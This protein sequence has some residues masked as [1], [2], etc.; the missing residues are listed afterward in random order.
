MHLKSGQIKDAIACF[1]EEFQFND[2]AIGLE[3]QDKQRLAEFFQKIRDL[4]PAS[5]ETDRILPSADHV[6]IEWTLRA[7]LAES[8]YSGLSRRVPISVH[9]ATIARVEYG[10]VKNW[11]DYYDGLASRRTSA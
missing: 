10:H 6:I 4:Y 8:F 1:A 2:W 11:S 9:G 7:L 5:L 3:F